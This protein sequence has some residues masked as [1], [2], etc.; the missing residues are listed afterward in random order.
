VDSRIIIN[1]AYFRKVNPNFPIAYLELFPF[2]VDSDLPVTPPLVLL[3]SPTET[4]EV[5]NIDV[6]VD[7]IKDEDLLIYSP[8]IYGF[9]LE[10]KL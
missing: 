7:I 9:S 10:D 1:A 8:I 2:G 5:K 4:G 3:L 6:D